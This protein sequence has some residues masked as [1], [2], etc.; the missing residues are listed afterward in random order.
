MG[1]RARM[2]E[3]E[4]IKVLVGKERLESSWGGRRWGD[5][6]D[7]RAETKKAEHLLS[8]ACKQLWGVFTAVSTSSKWKLLPLKWAGDGFEDE[9][10]QVLEIQRKEFARWRSA[11]SARRY[12]HSCF[13]W[14]NFSYEQLNETGGP[15]QFSTHTM[16]FLKV[17]PHWP[18]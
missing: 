7:Y 14:L 15:D 11:L 10:S 16:K 12:T 4:D 6:T 2:V 1:S 5:W 13:Q 17:V 9:Q 18:R 3:V 8:E